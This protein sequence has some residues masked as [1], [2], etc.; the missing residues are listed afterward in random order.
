MSNLYSIHA[1]RLA[2]GIPPNIK[3]YPPNPTHTPPTR[4]IEFTKSKNQWGIM[5]KKEKKTK[6]VYSSTGEK[7]LKEALANLITVHM[8]KGPQQ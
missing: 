8:Q 1:K 4:L 2:D 7:E 5:N 3:T 6:V